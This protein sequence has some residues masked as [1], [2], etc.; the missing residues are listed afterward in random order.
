MFK[1]LLERV[2][3]AGRF[4]PR[5]SPQEFKSGDTVIK[6]GEDITARYTRNASGTWNIS[7]KNAE[8]KHIEFDYADKEEMEEAGW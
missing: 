1:E 8:G 5:K 4:I 3:E 2:D 6:K 7:V